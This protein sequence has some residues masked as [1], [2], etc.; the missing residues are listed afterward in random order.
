V[1]QV[2]IS[3]WW[4]ARFNFGPIEWLWRSLMYG[5][6]QPMRKAVAELAPLAA[7]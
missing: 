7:E 4:L 6:S 3:R 5:R 2:I 1:T